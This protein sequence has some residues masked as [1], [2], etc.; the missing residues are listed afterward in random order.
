MT[1]RNDFGVEHL[2]ADKC[3]ALA[4]AFE[5]CADHLELNWTDDPL[6]REAG[7]LVMR[8]LYAQAAHW[9]KIGRGEAE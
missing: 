7:M 1:T 5:S 6:E 3:F 2:T 4:A 8:S 9:R